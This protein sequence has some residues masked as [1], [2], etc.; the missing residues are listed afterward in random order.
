MAESNES[1]ERQEDEG[2]E[3]PETPVTPEDP[4]SGAE[5]SP[6]ERDLT[7]YPLREAAADPRWAL[8]IVWGWTGF[9]LFCLA[10]VLALLV[11]GAFYD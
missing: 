5:P 9:T 2:P 11:L 7:S 1:D 10:F 3:T 6:L 8:R 4:G